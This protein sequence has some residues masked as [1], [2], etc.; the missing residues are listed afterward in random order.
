MLPKLFKVWSGKH[1]IG[2]FLGRHGSVWAGTCCGKRYWA[3][4]LLLDHY[5]AIWGHLGAKTD[6]F[7]VSGVT[8]GYRP[9]SG[10]LLPIV[11]RWPIVAYWPW[12]RRHGRSPIYYTNSLKP[13]TQRQ[14]IGSYA[15]Q[16][17]PHLLAPMG[18]KPPYGTQDPIRLT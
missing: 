8:S 3:Q 7:W 18:P 9:V 5:L 13:A 6:H 10:L 15:T 16:P 17:P 1:G 11:P 14:H 2:W 4:V 12:G